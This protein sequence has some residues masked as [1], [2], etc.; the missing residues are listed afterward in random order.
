MTDNG[1]RTVLNDRYEIQQRIGRGGMADV[2]LAR[3]LLLDRLVAIK[4]LFPEFATDPNFVERFR[5][6]AQS[7]ANLTHPNIVAVYDWGK[8]ANTY[9]MAMEYVQGRTLA[10][11]LRA[12]GHVNSVQAA[13]IANEVAAA[14]GNA[15]ASGV[16]HRDIKPANIL[17]GA[18]GQVKVADFGIARAMN[19]PSENNLTQVG[20]VMGTATYFSP[21]Q[22]QGAQPDPRSDL[23]SLGIV[24]YEMVAGKPPFA[25][26]NPVSIAYKQVH[27]LPQ[28]LNQLVADVPRPFEAIVA[29]LL[30]KD[31]NLRYPNAE[32]LRE[33]LRRY[34]SGE[35]VM[36]LASV[37]GAAAATLA[38]TGDTGS[39]ANV[40]RSLPRTAAN[41][42]QGGTAILSRTAI[43]QQQQQ[44]R[45]ERRNSWYG[46][47]AFIAL[48]A[49]IAGAV[50]LFNVL[51]NKEESAAAFALPNVVGEQLDVAGKKLQDLGLLLV[52]VEEPTADLAEGVV[53]RTEPVAET[54]V[55]KGQS[56]TVVYN[57]I[58]APV[59]I[60]NVKGMTVEEATATLTT[61]GFTVSPDTVFIVDSTLEPGKVLSTN[62][63]FG[64]SAVQGT[65]II[66][67]VSKAPDQQLV[68]EVTGQTAEA[69]KALLEAEPYTFA[70]TITQEPNATIAANT[71]LR[72][73][74]VA[75]TPV[76]KGVAVNVFV[77]AGPAKVKVPP[78]EG[79]TEA[80]ARNQLTNRG[81]VPDVQYVI[82]AVGSPDDGHVISQSIPPTDSVD[83]GTTIRLRVGKAAAAPSTTATPTTTTPAATTT[84]PP[85]A[86][87]GITKTGN[88][89]GS[90]VT[91]TI[92]ARNDG[93]FDVTG[94]RVTDIMPSGLT[95]VTWTCSDD[96]GANCPASGSN[97]ID[98]TVSLS[99]G[100]TVT[101]TVTATATSPGTVENTVTI[102]PPSGVT[103]PSPN[104]NSATDTRNVS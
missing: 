11:I 72:T 94:A 40:T 78:V 90:T 19:A 55:I 33:D 70:V 63:P 34:R 36:A 69:A 31:P 57:P 21:E 76:N 47:A 48:L 60:P 54:P 53:I 45:P 102:T 3:D 42:A 91:Y 22:A 46:I 17:I 84:T 26:E 80:A 41:P 38:R 18:N 82:V 77:S 51:K 98:V 87:L 79:L 29:K 88:V 44:R 2:F 50:V 65:A 86:N 39:A 25:G 30:A 12:N 89:S 9:F 5:R 28:P 37:V 73:D 49:L 24:L 96:P 95:L 99:V 15:H 62:P 85:T 68:P 81:L 10:D 56:I 101:F 7:A 75:N 20:S 6:E 100:T 92:I 67:T 52:L 43:L 13:E 58:K 104:N 8:Y 74:P 4:V 14:L 97:N 16:V 27:D 61:A 103:D 59:P 23:Y 71:V 32:A 93:P 64:E 83:P 1:E 35:P 66:L